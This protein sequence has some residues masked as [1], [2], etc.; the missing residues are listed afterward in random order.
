MPNSSWQLKRTAQC[1]ACPWIVGTDPHRD[2]PGGYSLK[3]HRA[4]AGTIADPDNPLSTLFAPTL[5]IMACHETQ[6]AH[7][8]GWLVNQT[9]PGNNLALRTS[10]R[11][12]QNAGRIR[13][14]GPQHERF[15]DTLPDSP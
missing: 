12:C 2:I 4:L 1:A 9:G 3:K 7:C 10:M 6:E 5:R 13:L 8:V 14:R 11:H 15:A